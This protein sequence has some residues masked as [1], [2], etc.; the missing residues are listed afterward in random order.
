[1]IRALVRVVS[2]TVHETLNVPVHAML[3]QVFL[4]LAAVRSH[5]DLALTF[6]HFAELHRAIDLADDRGFARLA[7]FEQR[8]SAAEGV[9][10]RRFSARLKPC[11]SCRDALPFRVSAGCPPNMVAGANAL[12]LAWL[13][14]RLTSCPDR[15][16]QSRGPRKYLRSAD[17]GG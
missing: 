7:G 8:T 6:G 13:T 5:V 9:E 16:H 4:L 1:M 15:K 11:P 14:A 12:I 17:L 10:R 3:H 2:W